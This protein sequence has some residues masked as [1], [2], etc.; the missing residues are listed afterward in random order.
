MTLF[1]TTDL[2]VV[3]LLGHETYRIARQLLFS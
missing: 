3:I 2:L 1:N